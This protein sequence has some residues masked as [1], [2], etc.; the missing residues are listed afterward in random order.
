MADTARTRT[1]QLL[2]T[3]LDG[4]L[5]DFVQSR[6]DESKSWRAVSR[7]LFS[8]TGFDVSDVTLRKWFHAGSAA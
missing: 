5:H 4:G 6:R 8:E 2:D 3:V 1:F 7:D